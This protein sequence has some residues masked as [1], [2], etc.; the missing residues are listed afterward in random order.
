M[1]TVRHRS[2][3]YYAP[4]LLYAVKY[5]HFGGFCLLMAF[6]QMIIITSPDANDGVPERL[7]ARSL[8][9]LAIAEQSIRI[10][11]AFSDYYH[12]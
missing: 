5:T 1:A 12:L 10:G 7:R 2:S 3:R 9:L 8:R 4:V 11:V 6:G